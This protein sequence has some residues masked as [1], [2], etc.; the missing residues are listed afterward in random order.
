MP[1]DQSIQSDQYEF[2][3]HHLLDIGG[4]TPKFRRHLGWG[5]EY[6]LYQTFVLN[7]IK[8]KGHKTVLDV[9]CGDGWMVNV[10]D[11]CGMKAS[12]I[13]TD[14]RAIQF[15]KAFSPEANLFSGNVLD[16][17]G[18]FDA[19]TLLEVLEHI[20]EG[21]ERDI[22]AKSWSLVA[23]GGTLYIMVPSTARPVHKKHFRHYNRQMIETLI[24]EANV[25][26][27]EQQLY[28]LCQDPMFYR[29]FLML[30]NN[31]RC[32]VHIPGLDRVV[33]KHYRRAALAANEENGLHIC[34]IATKRK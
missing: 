29:L 17:E 15:A 27:E 34:L 5:F 6:A 28:F 22:L 11:Q 8:T 24:A 2:P 1:G 16:M 4:A 20:P 14:E 33:W 7:K 13:D 23:P 32:A 25:E 3:Y 10:L 9:G 21:L 18:S 31:Q 12:G 26:S 19:V 30:I